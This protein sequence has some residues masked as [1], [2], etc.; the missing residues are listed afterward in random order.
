MDAFTPATLALITRLDYLLL[1]RKPTGEFGAGYRVGPGGKHRAGENDA[2]C[3]V[4]E[5]KEE[6]CVRLYPRYL[7]RVAEIISYRAF[8]PW[9]RVQV[10]QA[11]RYRYVP[12]TP[13]MT[14]DWYRFDALPRAEMPPSDLLWIPRVLRGEKLRITLRYDTRGKTCLRHQIQ[15]LIL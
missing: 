15:K 14:Y 3:L 5:T 13:E 11:S 8:T 10:Y 2:A 12:G 1:A 6:V 9:F 4:R 7:K